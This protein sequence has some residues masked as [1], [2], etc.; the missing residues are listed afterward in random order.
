MCSHALRCVSGRTNVKFVCMGMHMKCPLRLQAVLFVDAD[1]VC[2]H[3][4]LHRHTS[5]RHVTPCLWPAGVGAA[6]AAAAAA[7]GKLS[8]TFQLCAFMT[9][10]CCFNA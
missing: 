10:S 1:S 9:F 4:L 2:L 5:D 8:F 3:S 7:T 6:T